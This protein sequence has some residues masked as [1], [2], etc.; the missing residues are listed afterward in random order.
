MLRHSL[1]AVRHAANNALPLGE[2]QN[3]FL[4][5]QAEPT[6]IQFPNL[7]GFWRDTFGRCA[8]RGSRHSIGCGTI[9]QI[10]YLL[11]DQDTER[12]SQ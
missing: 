6:R 8:A 3:E 4:F 11:A 10:A 12:E 2:A 9:E 5:E 1:E 7:A